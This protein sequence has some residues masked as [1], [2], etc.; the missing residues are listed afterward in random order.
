MAGLDQTGERHS[1]GITGGGHT[2]RRG[3]SILDRDEHRRSAT[4]DLQTMSPDT[5]LPTEG[6]RR[7]R[8]HRVDPAP[9]QGFR[10]ETT[11]A[12][13]ERGGWRHTSA[14]PPRRG[15]TPTGAIAASPAKPGKIF[16][17]I[18][19][20]LHTSKVRGS[21]VLEASHRRHRNT[22]STK[23]YSRGPSTPRKPGS[24]R[25]YHPLQGTPALRPQPHGQIE[26]D[27]TR[28]PRSTPS[29]APPGEPPTQPQLG[30]GRPPSAL[31]EL[32]PG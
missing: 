30:G 28:P 14:T 27:L 4:K 5:M 3:G 17:C 1:L 32:L 21:T 18:A 20:H 24:P 2:L 31:Q 11:P 7:G 6:R 19:A 10:P 16:I 15:M 29:P 9:D 13:S 25:Q 22:S 12:P 8:R 26:P 23:P